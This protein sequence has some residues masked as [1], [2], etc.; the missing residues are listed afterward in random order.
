MNLSELQSKF[1]N[2]SANFSTAVHYSAEFSMQFSLHVCTGALVLGAVENC[3][4]QQFIIMIIII[5]I[6]IIIVIIII[7]SSSNTINTNTNTT[8][9]II[10]TI[11]V[12][13]N[14]NYI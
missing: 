13:T 10:N 8:I 6:I 9:I 11:I 1:S 12:Y 5:I 7:S 14:D 4:F 2:C 3:S